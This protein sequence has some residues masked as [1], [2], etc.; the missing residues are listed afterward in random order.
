M[1]KVRD[2]KGGT[3]PGSKNDKKADKATEN[4][5]AKDANVP[6]QLTLANAPVLS[7]KFQEAIALNL[8][9][10]HLELM[11]LNASMERIVKMAVE[12]DG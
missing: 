1:V 11:K 9:A 3:L 10:I 5:K 7:A 2:M 8:K 12:K 4:N 6:I